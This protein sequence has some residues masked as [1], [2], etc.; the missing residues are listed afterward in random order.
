MY[1]EGSAGGVERGLR[2][3]KVGSAERAAC[4]IHIPGEVSPAQIQNQDLTGKSRSSK[5]AP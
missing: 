1:Q 2:G 3:A 5:G 4:R